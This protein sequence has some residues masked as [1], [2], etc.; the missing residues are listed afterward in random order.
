MRKRTVART[1]RGVGIGWDRDHL[2]SDRSVFKNVHTTSDGVT[3][4][5]GTLVRL[6]AWFLKTKTG[7]K[8]SVNCEIS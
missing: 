1:R 4:G 3:I 2:P 7:G 5:E 6:S 8:E